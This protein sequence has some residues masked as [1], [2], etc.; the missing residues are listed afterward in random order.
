MA[1]PAPDP[2]R[3]SAR[4][5]AYAPVILAAIITAAALAL[6]IVVALIAFRR[7][8]PQTQVLGHSEMF[9]IARSLTA[10]HGFA[11]PFFVNSGPTAFISPGYPLIV[12][13]ILRI[14]GVSG[15][16]LVALVALQ[17]LFSTLTVWLTIRVAQQYFGVSTAIIAGCLCGFSLSLAI[18]PFWVWESC[19]SSLLLLSL[20][21]FLSRPRTKTQWAAA[22]AGVAVTT[23]INPALFPS[24]LFI[25]IWRAGHSRI[26]PW[27]GILIFLLVYAPWPARNLITMH[28][29]IPFRSNL[30]YELWMGNHPGADG[31]FHHDLDPEENPQERARFVALGELGYMRMKTS[32]A[33]DYIQTHPAE[34]FRLTLR[35]IADFWTASSEGEWP[36]GAA[37]VLLAFSGLAF[38]WRSH[39]EL[40]G[41]A[42]PLA[43]YPLPY[44][45]THADGRFRHMID[46]LLAILAAHAVVVFGRAVAAHRKSRQRE[47]E[48]LAAVAGN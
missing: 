46:P 41:Y 26:I 15:V 29:A 32:A 2:R 30:G 23:L 48:L 4:S 33:H 28:A 16:A 36:L 37:F 18:Q 6:R 40:R 7:C 22:G 21:A 11:S 47:D 19:L 27:L 45:F 31:R 39:P 44:Y 8:P 42:I 17:I 9:G 10:G 34:F 43:I 12:A 3:K 35:R 38:L 25:A 14:F 1:S 20:F 5:P 24:L 13:G